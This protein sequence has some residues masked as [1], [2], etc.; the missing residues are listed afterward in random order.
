MPLTP[1]LISN[2]V[3]VQANALASLFGLFGLFA[4]ALI[5]CICRHG[6]CSDHCPRPLVGRLG[7]QALQVRL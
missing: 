5:C 4:R 2:T 1:D 6:F 7:F 3:P